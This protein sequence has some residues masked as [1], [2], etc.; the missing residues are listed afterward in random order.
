M[1]PEPLRRAYAAVNRAYDTGDFEAFRREVEP[2]VPPD[3]VLGSS[4]MFPDHG[5]WHGFD[6]LLEFTCNQLDALEAPWIRIDEYLDRGDYIQANGR[7]GGR[8]RQTG[9]EFVI[10]AV[11]LWVIRD[12]RLLRLQVAQDLATALE[13]AGLG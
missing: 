9:I 4:G 8:A 1:N 10:P 13:A 6:G 12:G 7:F 3:F 2:L 11:H 5:E